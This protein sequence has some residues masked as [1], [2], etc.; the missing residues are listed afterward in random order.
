MRNLSDGEIELFAKLN[1]HEILLEYA[2][3]VLAQ[4]QPAPE[5]TLEIM[6]GSVTRIVAKAAPTGISQEDA[7]ALVQTMSRFTERFFGAVDD[8]VRTS[9]GRLPQR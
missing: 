4:M 8:R 1:Q 6:R 7:D 5:A 9:P 3:A 2:F